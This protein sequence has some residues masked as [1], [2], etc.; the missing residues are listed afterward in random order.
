MHHGEIQDDS[1]GAEYKRWFWSTPDLTSRSVRRWLQVVS[2]GF[3]RKP[4]IL[5]ALPSISLKCGRYWVGYLFIRWILARVP[6]VHT[7]AV[8]QAPRG[9]LAVLFSFIL[10]CVNNLGQELREGYGKAQTRVGSACNWALYLLT[11]S[12]LGN[13]STDQARCSFSLGISRHFKLPTEKTTF[14]IP[15]PHLSRAPLPYV[16]RWHHHGLSEPE[17]KSSL[18]YS[19]PSS[20]GSN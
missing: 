9:W 6:T 8:Y 1:V 15:Y 19:F 11:P 16:H 10:L 4:N 12:P 20:L 14:I 7:R 3:I 18:I 17:W 5:I 2:K 13:F